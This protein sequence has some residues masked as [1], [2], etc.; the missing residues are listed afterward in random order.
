MI[1]TF[2]TE[3]LILREVGTQDIPSY[4]KHFKDYEV[5]RN[6]AAIVPWPFP[7]DG[8]KSFLE[9]RIFPFQGQSLWMWGIFRQENPTELI[10]VVHLWREGKPEHRGFWLARPYWGRGYM[11]EAVAPVTDYAFNELG[12]TQLLF[13]NAV[14]NLRSRRIKE[15][16]GARL[17]RIQPQSF[18]D[19]L[20]TESEIWELNKSE[21][22]ARRKKV[23]RA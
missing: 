14:G 17:L 22:E 20:L 19:P 2:R 8:V 12:F 23:E 18:V 9:E 5:I 4:Q 6:L 21:W 1:P 7:D 15:K 10:G 16:T 3:R 13:S 11:T